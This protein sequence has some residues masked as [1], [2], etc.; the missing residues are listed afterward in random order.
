MWANC[1]AFVELQ[2]LKV[3]HYLW[4]IRLCDMMSRDRALTG[5]CASPLD[6]EDVSPASSPC[7]RSS[8]R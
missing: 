2:S 6:P 3:C 1:I 8:L 5:D 4:Q 7:E